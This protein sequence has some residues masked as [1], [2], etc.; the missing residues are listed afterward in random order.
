M[1]RTIETEFGFRTLI[2]VVSVLADK[3]AVGVLTALEPVLDT[4]VVTHNGSPRALEVERL[5]AIAE[6]IFGE[7]RVVSSPTM[8]DAVETAVALADQESDDEDGPASGVGVLITGSVVTA[9]A[10][11]SLFGK[12]P[13]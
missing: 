13:Q 1:A 9:G 2:G 5:A 11:R 4:V 12:E 7:D 10:A 6:E 8:V 3:D